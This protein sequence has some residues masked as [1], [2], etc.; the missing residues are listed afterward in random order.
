MEHLLD[1]L[2]HPYQEPPEGAGYRRPAP[3]SGEPYRTFCG[4]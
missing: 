2:S 4:T 1:V 3:P